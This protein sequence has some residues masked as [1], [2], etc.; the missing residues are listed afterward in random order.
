M[1]RIYLDCNATTPL[2][3]EVVHA[4]TEA[5]EKCVGNP[6]SVHYYGQQSSGELTKARRKLAK[7]WGVRPSEVTF[8]SGGTE[9]INLLIRGLVGAHQRGHVITSSAEH[10][11]VYETVKALESQGCEATF[12]SPG[13]W[14]AVQLAQVRE[15]IR[16]DTKLIVL[17]AANNETGVKTD[18]EGIAALAEEKKIPFVV[19]GVGI[20]GKERFSLPSG[21]SGMAISGHK[22]HAP[23]GVGSIYVRHGV[24]LAPVLTGGGHESGRRPGTENLPAIVAMAK[25]VELLDSHLPEATQQMKKMRDLLE[26]LLEEKVG[27]V[28]V[29]GKGP[30]VANTSNLFFQGVDG[31]SLLMQ[32]D[33]EGVCVSLGSACSAGVLQPSRVL[34]NMGLSRKEAQSSLRFS[35]SRFT[36]EEEIYQAVDVIQKIACKLRSLNEL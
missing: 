25:A 4:Y 3:P 21:V 23:K 5:L 2:A 10:S 17:M 26:S 20:F 35:V 31:E 28:R 6:S 33:L 27:Q 29:N 18:L 34:L 13:E 12:L 19:D 32:L 36:T 24:T 22:F 15:A 30:R 8:T 14:G 7:F 1:R 9:G 11:A 16:A